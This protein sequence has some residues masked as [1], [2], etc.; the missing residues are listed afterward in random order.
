MYEKDIQLARLL[1][2]RQAELTASGDRLR[3]QEREIQERIRQIHAGVEERNQ[4]ADILA[5]AADLLQRSDLTVEAP[6]TST[7]ESELAEVAS[8][9]NALTEQEVKFRELV[10]ALRERAPQ[11][12]DAATGELSLADQP[13][14]AGESSLQTSDQQTDSANQLSQTSPDNSVHGEEAESESLTINQAD[15]WDEDV[16]VFVAGRTK[17]LTP[18]D[19]EYL[20]REAARSLELQT[21][22]ETSQTSAA[23]LPS[24]PDEPLTEEELDR[25]LLR[26]NMDVIQRQVMQ[27]LGPDAVFVVDAAS[28]MNNIPYYDNAIRGGPV[29]FIREELLRDFGLLSRHLDRKV[30]LVLDH[31]HTPEAPL[32]AGVT[33]QT[34]H[35]GDQGQRVA[36]DTLLK[37]VLADAAQ[38]TQVCLVTGE[39]ALGGSLRSRRVQFLPVT[40]FFRM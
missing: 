10:D 19:E 26:F 2:E 12:F 1:I 27:T 14:H 9:L 29:K 4:Y 37:S 6:D 34:L 8:Q 16:K 39:L 18:E 20:A 23:T 7:E 3:E 38:H 17:V 15:D 21:E 13:S 5:Q 25:F 30:H 31:E 35:S 33:L 40:D 24:A 28:V 22:E 11:L 36:Q 32:F